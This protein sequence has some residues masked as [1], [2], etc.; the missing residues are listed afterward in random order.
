MRAK[1]VVR[2][3]DEAG[4]LLGWA[5]LLA[6]ARGDRALRAIQKCVVPIEQSGT[7]SVVSYHWTDMNVQKRV[8][9]AAG[10]VTEGQTVELTFADGI[11]LSMPSDDGPLPPVTVRGAVAVAVP[12]AAMGVVG[13]GG[14]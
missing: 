7:P 5:P 1:I 14:G 12:S 9:Y 11:V 6:E 10:P 13:S 2:I 3:L 8:P 4:A